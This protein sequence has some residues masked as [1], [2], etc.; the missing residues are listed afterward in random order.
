V[1]RDI[2]ALG[3][4]FYECLTSKYPFDDPTPPI[5][6]QPKD[7]KQFKGCADFSSSL[8]NILVKMIAPERK[9]RFTSVDEFLTAM[10]EV[11]RLR[12]V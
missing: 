10:A 2:Y 6:T 4:T 8:V 5:K 7:P 11:K 3:I 1:D 12:S 9:E